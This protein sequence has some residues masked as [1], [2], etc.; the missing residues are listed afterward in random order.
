MTLWRRGAGMRLTVE[1]QGAGI[2]PEDVKRLFQPFTRLE[3]TRHMASG[4][5]LG[6]VSVQKII[7]AHGGDL[8]IFSR[9]GHGTII[10]IFL[11]MSGE[12]A[13]TE[14]SPLHEAKEST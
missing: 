5:G 14:S 3:G 8:E 12:A 1:D 10:E 4:T 13:I 2:A 6:L 11:K 7:H 9:P